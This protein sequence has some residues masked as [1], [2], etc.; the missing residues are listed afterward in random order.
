MS[1]FKIAGLVATIA[2]TAA[3]HGHVSSVVVGGATLSGYEPNYQYK[4]PAPVVAGWSDPLAQDNGFVEPNSYTNPD[5][6]CHKGAT[7]GQAT[8]PV[9][10]GEDV[11]FLWTVPWPDSHHGPIIT[12][13]AKCPGDCATVDKT[14]LEFVKVD[15]VGLVTPGQTGKWASDTLIAQNSSWTFTI[16]E[17]IAPGQYVARH[18]IIALHSAGQANGAQNYPQCINLEVSGSGTENPT[19]TLGTELYKA[20]DPSIV[21]NIYTQID[22]YAI[23]GP[24]LWAGA[25]GPAGGSAGGS[26]SAAAPTATA[27]SGS[28]QGGSGGAAGGS[29]AQSSG[30]STSAT[31]A[32]GSTGAASTRAPAPTAT[33]ACKRR[34]RAAHL[35]V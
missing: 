4:T 5:I 2:A 32:A 12:Y 33:K 19:G 16:P 1:F 29:S 22:S 8:I 31:A 9:N 6:I 26:S 10:A 24:T 3:A 21:F 25:A 27:G 14:T 7:P 17:S 23:P 28:S 20:D 34:R 13:L 11:T 18:E 35:K 15:A 30:A